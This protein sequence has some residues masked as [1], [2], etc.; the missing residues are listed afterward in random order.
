MFFI[1]SQINVPFAAN[2]IQ[3]FNFYLGLSKKKDQFAVVFLFP[4]SHLPFFF[5][6]VNF[7]VVGD[8]L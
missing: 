4:I 8:K 5:K 1:C 6:Q 7:G 3:D 2:F